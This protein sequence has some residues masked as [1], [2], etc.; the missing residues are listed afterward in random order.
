VSP[1][2]LFHPSE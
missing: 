1:G 2:N